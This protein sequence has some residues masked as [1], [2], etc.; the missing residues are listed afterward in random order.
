MRPFTSS[1]LI[2]ALATTILSLDSLPASALGDG[3]RGPAMGGSHGSGAGLGYRGRPQGRFGRYGGGRGFPHCGRRFGG[4]GV[5]VYAGYGFGDYGWAGY[6]YNIDPLL[7]REPLIPERESAVPAVAGIPAPPVAPP[8]IYVIG[9]DRAPS[10]ERAS[11]RRAGATE[12]R[13]VRVR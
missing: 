2:A 11:R 9:D 3:L 8:A 1:L 5:P 10:A 12:P 7:L 13:V 6:N 4:C